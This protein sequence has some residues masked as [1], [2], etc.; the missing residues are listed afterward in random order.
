MQSSAIEHKAAMDKNFI[1]PSNFDYSKYS[2]LDHR[3]TALIVNAYL[4]QFYDW[5]DALASDMDKQ[6]TQIE[7]ELET[8]DYKLTGFRNL[9]RI[10]E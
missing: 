7:R 2:A 6:E 10:S 3:K 1:L 9:F 8:M 5:F 4:D